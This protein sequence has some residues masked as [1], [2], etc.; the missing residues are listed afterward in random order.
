MR[1]GRL[2]AA[3]PAGCRLLVMSRGA[4]QARPGRAT[5][6]RRARFGPRPP[7]A[8]QRLPDPLFQIQQKL[9]IVVLGT[10]CVKVIFSVVAEI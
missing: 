5:R 9:V 7:D 1:P 10:T 6:G 4:G 2:T 3:R 8:G